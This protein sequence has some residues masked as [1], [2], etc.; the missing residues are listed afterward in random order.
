MRK[1]QNYETKKKHCCGDHVQKPCE[2]CGQKRVVKIEPK[3]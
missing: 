2:K 1:I 3:N